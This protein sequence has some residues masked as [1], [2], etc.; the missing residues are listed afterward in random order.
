MSH[1]LNT[2]GLFDSTENFNR[3][4]FY[5]AQSYASYFE[6]ICE[7]LYQL[8]F[9]RV[10]VCDT[11][12]KTT[13]TF[14]EPTLV[15]TPNITDSPSVIN[16]VLK[17]YL[18]TKFRTHMTA[19][20]F[21]NTARNISPLDSNNTIDLAFNDKLIGRYYP[22]RNCVVLHFNIFATN[23][24]IRFALGVID[25][26]HTALNSRNISLAI[27]SQLT[28][29][30]IE[31]QEKERLE[32]L[33]AQK[34]EKQKQVVSEFTKHISD[35]LNKIK[36]SIEYKA[37]DIEDNSVRIARL[38][39]EIIADK[40]M[41]PAYEKMQTMSFQDLDTK[42]NEIRSLPFVTNVYLNEKGIN[43]EIGKISLQVK[44]KKY[45]IGDFVI[46]ITANNIKF[47]NKHRLNG[48][49]HPHISSGS[50]CWG[51]HQSDVFK[52]LGQ[53]KFK[54]LVFLLYQ[55]LKNY[56][57]DGGGHPYVSIAEWGK[58]RINE[59]KYDADGNLLIQQI[60]QEVK[61]Q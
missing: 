36:S 8:G 33:E 23:R 16:Q 49:E 27:T 56:N 13:L 26:L 54:E 9:R 61:S 2:Q 34:L 48:Y 3:L 58:Q 55:Y 59:S 52:L 51:S 12:T 24:K 29:E 47:S 25:V 11:F 20:Q 41:L 21:S 10:S 42:V 31:K 6:Q 4:C 44:D 19:A 1:V 28:P 40:A 53:M 5:N 17:E 43:V 50:P 7:K 57:D 46:H 35:E 60:I 14:T 22:Q 37:K 39:R 45:Y 18:Y 32:R 30:Q 38:T 15:M